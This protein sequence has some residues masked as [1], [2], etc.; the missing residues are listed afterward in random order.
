MRYK[1]GMFLFV[2]LL[3][4]NKYAYSEN[5][6]VTKVTNENIKSIFGIKDVLYS[7]NIYLSVANEKINKYGTE[8]VVEG[9]RINLSF[10]YR[11]SMKGVQLI[12]VF[13]DGNKKPLIATILPGESIEKEPFKYRITAKAGNDC[14][15]KYKALVIIKVNNKL[16]GNSKSFTTFVADCA[17]Q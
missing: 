1:L 16:I 8:Y 11:G 14:L 2:L 10:G 6:T 7:E 9:A 12:G 15:G 17:G 4:S 5:L 13:L 3:I